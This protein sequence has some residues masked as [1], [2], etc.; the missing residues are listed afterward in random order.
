MPSEAFFVGDMA[1]LKWGLFQFQCS[2]EGKYIVGLGALLL[3]YQTWHVA[4]RIICL[5][6][7]IIQTL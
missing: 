6:Q 2:S 3:H 4:G 1:R 7:F 5:F